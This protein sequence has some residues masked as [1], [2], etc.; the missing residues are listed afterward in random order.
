M[1][2]CGCSGGNNGVSNPLT[3]ILPPISIEPQAVPVQGSNPS[4]GRF[5]GVALYDGIAL[6]VL[7]FLHY[8]KG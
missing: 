7:A 3:G 1:L 2:A 4:R 6:G 8:S 5:S